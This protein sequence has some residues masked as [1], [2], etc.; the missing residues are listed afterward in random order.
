V[1]AADDEALKKELL[2]DG[3]A[4]AADAAAILERARANALLVEAFDEALAYVLTIG[5]EALASQVP[6]AGFAVAPAKK[7]M[8]RLVDDAI[9]RRLGK[10]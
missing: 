4:N 1:S 7:V 5:G 10:G 9:D 3:A 6:G 8:Q 2:A